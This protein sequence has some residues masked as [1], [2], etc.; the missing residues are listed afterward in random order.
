MRF[1]K[2]TS[3]GEREPLATSRKWV[4]GLGVGAALMMI[5]FVTA[6]GSSGYTG[7]Q[8][9]QPAAP[10]SQA[11]TPP[12]TLPAAPGGETLGAATLA[13]TCDVTQD[14]DQPNG[15]GQYTQ[16]SYSAT[17]TDSGEA[18]SVTSFTLT[19]NDSA[20]AEIY[21]D[22]EVSWWQVIEPGQS[23]TAAYTIDDTVG[24][25]EQPTS[26]QVVQWQGQG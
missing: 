13:W 24:L 26:C 10:T 21:S 4:I 7:V 15:Q 1:T 22:P 14:P 23:L 5:A 18:A 17:A 12:A 9:V 25:P 8:P 16:F 3:E 20:G 6:C 11:P 2:T 19:F